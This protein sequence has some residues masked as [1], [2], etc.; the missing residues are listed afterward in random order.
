MDTTAAFPRCYASDQ[1]NE[2]TWEWRAAEKVE[3]VAADLPMRCRNTDVSGW[4]SRPH[5]SKLWGA[6]PAPEKTEPGS[7]LGDRTSG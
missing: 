1:P 6:G 4:Q 2:A 7:H 3:Y 5:R